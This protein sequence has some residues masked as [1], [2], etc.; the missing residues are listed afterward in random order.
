[1]EWNH[2]SR[3]RSI[4][5]VAL[6]NAVTRGNARCATLWHPLP[7]RVSRGGLVRGNRDRV[8]QGGTDPLTREVSVNSA[9]AGWRAGWG[10]LL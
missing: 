6:E 3:G 9:T 2:D 1:M 10:W 7:Y 5:R 8:A 4:K